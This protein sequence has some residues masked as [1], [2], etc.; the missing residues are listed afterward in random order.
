MV[1]FS[2]HL[3]L[4]KKEIRLSTVFFYGSYESVFDMDGERKLSPKTTHAGMNLNVAAGFHSRWNGMFTLPIIYNAVDGYNDPGG[5]ST[6]KKIVKQGDLELGLKYLVLS[7]EKW[8]YCITAWQS[9]GTAKR[10]DSTFL[11][12]G[13][14]DYNSRIYFDVNYKKSLKWSS[15]MYLGF[16]KRNKSNSDEVHAGITASFLIHKNLFFDARGELNYSL[17]NQSKKPINYELGLFHNNARWILAT[18]SFRYEIA[19]RLGGFVSY[20]VPIRGQ[21]VYNTEIISVG[22]TLKLSKSANVESNT[23]STTSY[24]QRNNIN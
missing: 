22:I 12:T 13:Y 20:T 1:T 5:I 15:G 24:F 14:A 17:E 21:Y 3:F 11:H 10:D 4:E 2:Q 9:L 6:E 19:K 18:G 23:D 16:N 7:N 8:K